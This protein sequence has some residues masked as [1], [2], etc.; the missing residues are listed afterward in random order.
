[1]DLR[2]VFGSH[3]I[4]TADSREVMEWMGHQDLATTQRYLQFKPR[5]DAA[6]R[7]SAA[8]SEEAPKLGSTAVGPRAGVVRE[9]PN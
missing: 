4:R 3:A 5:Q 6:R 9:R 8:F 1:H 7:I 2:H